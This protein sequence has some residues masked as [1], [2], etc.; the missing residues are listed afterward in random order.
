ME[1]ICQPGAKEFFRRWTWLFVLARR[2]AEWIVSRSQDRVHKNFW[3]I[4]RGAPAQRVSMTWLLFH[5]AHSRLSPHGQTTHQQISKA[6]S[7]RFSWKQ[8]LAKQIKL[9]E[10][11]NESAIFVA[12]IFVAVLSSANWE[13]ASAVNKGTSKRLSPPAVLPLRCERSLE[14]ESIACAAWLLDYNKDIQIISNHHFLEQQ[15][16]VQI[17]WIFES[18][19][20]SDWVLVN[21][22]FNSPKIRHQRLVMDTRAKPFQL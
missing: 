16:Q 13:S 10:F 12:E 20:I 4:L 8:D 21:V 14:E 3:E 19:H 17:H 9:N 15:S 2:V 11:L 5:C 7:V 18:S 6:V 1:N 22:V